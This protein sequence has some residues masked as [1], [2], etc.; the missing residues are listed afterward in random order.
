MDLCLDGVEIISNASA[1][2]HELRKLNKRLQLI[3]S[4]SARN[5]CVYMY[6]NQKGGDGGRLYFDGSSLVVVNGEIVSQLPQFSLDD[7][8]VAVVNIDLE[9]VRATRAASGSRTN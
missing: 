4:A 1:S 3:Q 7:V 2:H 9:A 6:A 5:E 8:E